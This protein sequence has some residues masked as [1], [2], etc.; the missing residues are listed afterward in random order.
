MQHVQ[1]TAMPYMGTDAYLAPLGAGRFCCG[2]GRTK[3]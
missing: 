3:K 2:F 1:F